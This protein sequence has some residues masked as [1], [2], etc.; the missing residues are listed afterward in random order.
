MISK[1]T[2]FGG[3]VVVLLIGLVVCPVVTARTY[4]GGANRWVYVHERLYPEAIS[5]EGIK[6]IP[7][8]TA[9]EYTV[10]RQAQ[11]VAAEE[12]DLAAN[13]MTFVTDSADTVGKTFIAGADVVAKTASGGAD[14][15]GKTAVNGA[16][17]IGWAFMAV[18]G[19]I[20][21]IERQGAKE[22]EVHQIEKESPAKIEERK[23]QY[24]P[25]LHGRVGQWTRR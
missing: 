5:T 17:G 2:I 15:V 14:A 22:Y 8:E 21:E 1:K 4:N 6:E 25:R 10:I 16:N 3:V 20:F 23:S 12:N 19:S 11:P 24:H 13:S 9:E 18:Y 7:E